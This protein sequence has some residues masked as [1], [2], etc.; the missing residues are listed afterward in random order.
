MRSGGS[1]ARVPAGTGAA[2]GGTMGYRPPP[3][4]M[5]EEMA[6]RGRRPCRD[7]RLQGPEISRHQFFPADRLLPL[8]Q[9]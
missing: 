9:P 1:P 5:E 8:L 7:P 3:A 4:A 2:P 6:A